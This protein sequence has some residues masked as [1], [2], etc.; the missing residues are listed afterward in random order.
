[1]TY[2]QVVSP[3]KRRTFKTDKGREV[4]VWSASEA[5]IVRFESVYQGEAERYARKIYKGE[6]FIPEL[7]EVA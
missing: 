5:P 7:L 3:R 4:L 6:G 1:M 2:F